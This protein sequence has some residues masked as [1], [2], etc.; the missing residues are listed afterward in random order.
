MIKAKTYMFCSLKI[1]SSRPSLSIDTALRV[2]PTS[3]NRSKF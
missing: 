2:Q 1:N 3:I